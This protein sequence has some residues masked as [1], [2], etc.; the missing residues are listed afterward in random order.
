MTLYLKTGKKSVIKLVP[1]GPEGKQ[2]ERFLKKLIAAQRRM[3]N[4]KTK[5]RK[6]EDCSSKG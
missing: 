3:Y 6:S 1:T 4:A 5:R 2:A